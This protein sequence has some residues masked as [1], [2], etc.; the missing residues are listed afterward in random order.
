MIH[1]VHAYL[2]TQTLS[3]W[4]LLQVCVC[5]AFVCTCVCTYLY[6]Y[7]INVYVSEL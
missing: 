4:E 3:A 6:T 7:N 5:V 2:H 1:D